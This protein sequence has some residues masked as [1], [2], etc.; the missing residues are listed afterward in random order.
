MSTAPKK[1]AT[2]TTS[3][4]T[5]NEVLHAVQKGF[6][7]AE[8]RTEIEFKQ[9]HERI[10]K[11]ERGVRFL[12]TDM[13]NLKEQVGDIQRRSINLEHRSADIIET[14]GALSDAEDKDAEASINHER[15]IAHLEKLGGIK[16]TPP[17]HLVA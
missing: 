10:E 6:S 16:S 14:L 5:L 13:N 11:V 2:P 17:A 1:K 7:S 4:A 12:R 8:E 3:E 15:R 9:L